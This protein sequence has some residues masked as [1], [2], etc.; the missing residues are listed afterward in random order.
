MLS[1]ANN[2][3]ILSA[4][5]T[6]LLKRKKK[7]EKTAQKTATPSDISQL[8]YDHKMGKNLRCKILLKV[9]VLF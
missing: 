7:K 2:S 9:L 3:V 4:Q 6:E 1:A 8:Q 5:H